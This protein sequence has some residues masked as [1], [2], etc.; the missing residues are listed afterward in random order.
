MGGARAFE[1]ESGTCP[2]CSWSVSNS[3]TLSAACQQSAEEPKSDV[4]VKTFFRHDE[5]LGRKGAPDVH[6]GLQMQPRESVV[7]RDCH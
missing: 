4:L 3:G 7:L 1:A 5:A 6:T 2:A